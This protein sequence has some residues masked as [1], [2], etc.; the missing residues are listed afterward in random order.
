MAPT[1]L[2]NYAADIEVELDAQIAALEAEIKE[3]QRQR[4][5][6]DLAMEDK[7]KLG[8]EIKRLEGDMDD[9]KPSK[10][11]RRRDIQRQVGEM[12]DELSASLGSKPSL[13]LLFTVRWT[14]T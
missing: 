7:L 9:L 12:L 6:V 10:F 11:E 14:V 3:L 4:R 5:A 8:R 1:R 2:D 13:K